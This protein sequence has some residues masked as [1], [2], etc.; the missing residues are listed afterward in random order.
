MLSM[1][2]LLFSGARRVGISVKKAIDASRNGF[3]S[4]HVQ[5]AKP[6]F[7]LNLL[8]TDR[9]I[10]AGSI[11]RC[12]NSG[13]GKFSCTVSDFGL[14]LLQGTADNEKNQCPAWLLGCWSIISMSAT[15][16]SSSFKSHDAGWSP[17]S[18]DHHETEVLTSLPS[19]PG[20]SG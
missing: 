6:V 2:D 5:A 1:A 20:S 18:N 3:F 10:V 16:K 14:L 11:V 15:K 7:G 8:S 19:L 12:Q 13:S 4:Q 17:S 9:E